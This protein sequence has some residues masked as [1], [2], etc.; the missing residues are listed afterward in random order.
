V[1]TARDKTDQMA[2]E[3][4]SVGKVEVVRTGSIAIAC[5]D[6]ALATTTATAPLPRRTA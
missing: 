2:R 4:S 6:K 3:L 5:G 1:T